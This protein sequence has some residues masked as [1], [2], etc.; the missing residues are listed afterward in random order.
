MRIT[1]TFEI[2]M[3]AQP[4]LSEVDGVVIAPIQFDKQFSGPLTATSVVH[5]IGTRGPVEGSAGY[6]AMERV[7]GTLDGKT[8]TFVLQHSGT[9][10]AGEQALTV[11]VVP[12]SGTGELAGLRGTCSIDIVERKHHYALDYD[13]G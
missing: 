9:M 12:G 6:V 11:T 7:T 8:G 1:G 13:L 4:P 3:T 5:M 2:K 10:H